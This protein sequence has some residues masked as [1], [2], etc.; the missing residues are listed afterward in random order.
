MTRLSPLLLALPL[1]ASGCYGSSESFAQKGAKLACEQQQECNKS[2]F[3]SAFSSMQDCVDTRS[4]D[5]VD[6]FSSCEYDP[7]QGRECISVTKQYQ[8]E[9]TPNVS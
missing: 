2:S 6:A 1:L 7:K 5:T 4:E 8:S 9:C 3:E